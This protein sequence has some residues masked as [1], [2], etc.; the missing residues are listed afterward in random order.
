[1]KSQE[2]RMTKLLADLLHLLNEIDVPTGE[3]QLEC[4]CFIGASDAIY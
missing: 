3:E 2:E 1:M 4:G